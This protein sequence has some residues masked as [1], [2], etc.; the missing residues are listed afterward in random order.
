MQLSLLAALGWLG[1]NKALDVVESPEESVRAR[2]RASL[3][4][5]AARA[6]KSIEESAW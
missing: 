2:E 3:A 5:W 6:R 1:W 4:W